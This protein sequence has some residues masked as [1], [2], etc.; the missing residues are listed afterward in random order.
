[1]LTFDQS[2]K[3]RESREK[4]LNSMHAH[5][6]GHEIKTSRP[7]LLKIEDNNLI[8]LMDYSVNIEVRLKIS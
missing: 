6:S 2:H 8:V 5:V 3:S 7:P 4:P 1:M